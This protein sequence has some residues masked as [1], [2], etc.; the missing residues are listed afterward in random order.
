MTLSKNLNELL[1]SN[2]L[3]A[4]KQPS[5]NR[6]RLILQLLI[7]KSKNKHGVRVNSELIQ[8]NNK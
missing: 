6:P 7:A 1:I 2:V 3:R 5:F 4:G 8:S